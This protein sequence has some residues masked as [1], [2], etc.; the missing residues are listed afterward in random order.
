MNNSF[1]IFSVVIGWKIQ[2]AVF[3]SVERF[4]LY[5]HVADSAAFYILIFLQKKLNIV[6]VY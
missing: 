4:P 5:M 2:S 1:R 3:F 6:A